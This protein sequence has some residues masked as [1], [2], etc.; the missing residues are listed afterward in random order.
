MLEQLVFEFTP[1]FQ[2]KHLTCA[3]DAPPDFM[4]KCDVGKMQRV[5]D[6]LLRNAVN[7][8]FADSSIQITMTPETDRVNLR[9]CN[10]GNTIPR[11][12]LNRVFEQFYRLD[13]ARTS[14]C[15]GAGLGLAIAKEIVELHHGAIKAES[16]NETIVFELWIPLL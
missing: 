10:Q 2:E 5:F 9:F 14:R 7:Y 8:S 16:E 1:L 3:L 6:N 12:K 4:V 15:G 11:E 13:A